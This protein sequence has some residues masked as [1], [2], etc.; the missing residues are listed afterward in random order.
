MLIHM[1]MDAWRAG[2]DE[3]SD[4]KDDLQENRRN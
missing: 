3:F 2:I 1:H 4:K